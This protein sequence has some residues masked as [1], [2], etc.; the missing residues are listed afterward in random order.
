MPP[1]GRHLG[2]RNVEG[3]MYSSLLY[4]YICLIMF[5]CLFNFCF[6]CLIPDDIFGFCNLDY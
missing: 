2:G 1:V 5:A 3:W 6:V 4:L